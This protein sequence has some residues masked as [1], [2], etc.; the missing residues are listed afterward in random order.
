MHIGWLRGGCESFEWREDK[1]LN[2]L[3]K[4]SAEKRCDDFG[5]GM[6]NDT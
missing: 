5:N 6:G 4:S 3:H 1:A 2:L